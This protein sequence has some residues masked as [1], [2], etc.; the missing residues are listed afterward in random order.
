LRQYTG[1][2]AGDATPGGWGSSNDEIR[3]TNQ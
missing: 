3:V 2:A 1:V